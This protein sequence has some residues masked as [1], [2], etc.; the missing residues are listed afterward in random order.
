MDKLRGVTARRP[1]LVWFDQINADYRKS[2]D[3]RRFNYSFR[4]KDRVEVDSIGFS[5]QVRIWTKPGVFP[6]YMLELN[7]IPPGAVPKHSSPNDLTMNEGTVNQYPLTVFET[8]PNNYEGGWAE[9]EDLVEMIFTLE[10]VPDLKVT[11][12]DLNAEAEASVHYFRDSLQLPLKRTNNSEVRGQEWKRSDVETFYLGKAPA[13]LRVYDK[14]QEM[15]FRGEDV[16]QLPKT[17]TRLEWELRGVRC[18]IEKFV[19]IPKLL[20]SCHPFAAI[21]LRDIPDYY[22]F[23]RDPRRSVNLLTYRTLAEREGGQQARKYLNSGRNFN[24]DYRPFLVDNNELKHTIEKSFHFGNQRLLSGKGASIKHLYV[25]C[26]LCQLQGVDVKPC[27]GCGWRQCD[28]CR[29]LNEGH[30]QTCPIRKENEN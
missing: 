16:S 19:D 27:Q 21:Q 20:P 26:S 7:F 30:D 29:E 15:I 24:R 3:E 23:K 10:N 9:L 5:S 4:F 2:L 25:Y 18:P 28:G 14:I 11:R 17:L 13:R 1:G 6:Q 8:N 22:D 12:L